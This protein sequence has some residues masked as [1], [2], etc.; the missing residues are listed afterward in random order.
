MFSRVQRREAQRL[1]MVLG[2]ISAIYPSSNVLV[3]GS[4]HMLDW[5]GI[6]QVKRRA[7]LWLLDNE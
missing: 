5:A 1:T 2:Q 4:K 7:I 6:E 3:I